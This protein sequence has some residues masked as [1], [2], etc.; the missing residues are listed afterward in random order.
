M[1]ADGLAAVR[2]PAS[3]P[4]GAMAAVAGMAA[5]CCRSA[6]ASRSVTTRVMS[7][8][9]L[10]GARPWMGRPMAS[11]TTGTL[12]SDRPGT[13]LAPARRFT[14]AAPAACRWAR[15]VAQSTT[16][17]RNRCSRTRVARVWWHTP[18]RDLCANHRYVLLHEPI[19]AARSRHGLRLRAIHRTASKNEPLSAALRARALDRLPLI[20]SKLPS[21]RPSNASNIGPRRRVPVGG[22]RHGA[23]GRSDRPAR[24]LGLC[25][26]RQQRQQH[27]RRRRRALPW[28]AAPN[29]PRRFARTC[30]GAHR[31]DRRRA[32]RSRPAADQSLTITLRSSV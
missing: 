12:A 26:A 19:S 9:G 32:T 8:P 30:T 21:H 10:T 20:V 11:T 28:A 27:A 4:R 1:P 17:S 16:T 31:C 13:T 2:R 6:T 5:N 3:A 24:H 23:H 15:T 18:V 25:E 22:H 7:G 14:S 29:A